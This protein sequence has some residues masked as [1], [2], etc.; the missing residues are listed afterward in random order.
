MLKNSEINLTSHR[1]KV[2][3]EFKELLNRVSELEKKVILQE[4][5]N[6]KDVKIQL[7][8][9]FI[10]ADAITVK[11]DSN[12]T[13][14]LN[15][16]TIAPTGLNSDGFVIEEGGT[17]EIHGDGLVETQAGGLGF[18]IVAHGNVK[19]YGGDYVSHYDE[20]GDTNACIYAKGNGKVEIYGGH[21]ET[22]TGIFTL[23]VHNGSLNTASIVVYGGE[24]VNF[25]PSNHTEAAGE[26]EKSFVAEG[27][28][29]EAHVINPQKT[30]YKVVKE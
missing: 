19:I 30:I 7:N 6:E 12:V 3:T 2:E 22:E 4:L 23:N 26:E 29:V 25:D 17:L 8:S 5:K 13:V 18:P 14:D 20:N 1:V 15:G 24:F 28:K 10:N 16:H 11:S 21:F 9:D 27:Y